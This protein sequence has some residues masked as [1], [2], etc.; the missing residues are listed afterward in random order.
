MRESHA[1][2]PLWLAEAGLTDIDPGRGPSFNQVS[3][4]IDAAIEGQGVAMVRSALDAADLLAGR[5]V[6]PFTVERP[7]P[8]AYWVVCPKAT[9]ER[10]KIRAFRDWLLAEAATDFERL[11]GLK[12]PAAALSPKRGRRR[13]S[14]RP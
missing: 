11:K 6:R 8:Y 10:P 5:L 2:W 4:A 3:L 9:A 7:A 13:A 1:D 12:P 14:V